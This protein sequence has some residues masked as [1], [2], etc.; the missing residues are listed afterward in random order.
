MIYRHG[1]IL[2]SFS[3]RGGSN[4]FDSSEITCPTH[5][6]QDN[7][8]FLNLSVHMLSLFT[9]HGQA[10]LLSHLIGQASTCMDKMC[11]SWVTWQSGKNLLN[12]Q[13]FNVG[14]RGF[15]LYAQLDL[16]IFSGYASTAIWFWSKYFISDRNSFQRL[17]GNFHIDSVLCFFVLYV[18]M[19]DKSA[20]CCIICYYFHCD[21]FQL[22]I[23]ITS[24]PRTNYQRCRSKYEM[25]HC[26]KTRLIWHFH[27]KSKKGEKENK[28]GSL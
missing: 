26:V 24:W 20:W 6:K 23:L 19:V 14:T 10:L 7:R 1:K 22:I 21:M 15:I 8:R 13:N 17:R 9:K 3:Y 25:D 16:A 4:V 18:W 28:R 5:S 12:F 2:C 27:A 11:P